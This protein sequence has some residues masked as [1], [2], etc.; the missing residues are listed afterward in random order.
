[1][2]KSFLGCCL[3]V[4]LWISPAISAC[5]VQQLADELNNDPA[6][7]GYAPYIASGSDKS[8][9]TLINQVQ[10]GQ[11][12]FISKGDSTLDSVR[13]TWGDVIQLIEAIADETSEQAVKNKEAKWK[14]LVE[15][16]LLSV[17]QL[18][19]SA[20][21]TQS[22]FTQAIAD[23]LQYYSAPGVPATLTQEV[24]DVRVGRQ[25][26]RAEVVCGTGTVV[27]KKDVSLALRGTE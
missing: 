27:K 17:D 16:L 3:L 1:M 13:G 26:S 25:G 12:Y 15:T 5:S 20:P 6:N 22:F 24:V 7:V 4:I 10:E 11:A 23:E 8:I 2:M 14:W 19:Y 21:E 18:D 9:V